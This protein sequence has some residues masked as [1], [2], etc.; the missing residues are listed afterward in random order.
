[1]HV[2]T[3]RARLSNVLAWFQPTKLWHWAGTPKRA[4]FWANRE[5]GTCIE[6]LRVFLRHNILLLC[7]PS[8]WK[9]PFLTWTLK[10]QIW[11]REDKG[12]ILRTT[13][14]LQSYSQLQVLLLWQEPVQTSEPS[15]PLMWRE[16]K[17]KRYRSTSVLRRQATCM[18]KG[19]TGC[20]VCSCFSEK[21]SI[22][23]WGEFTFKAST[24][25]S[26]RIGS[27]NSRV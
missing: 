19:L 7:L 15:L 11:R 13:R 22:E 26:M 3:Q 18:V 4:S 25:D 24:Q 21:K 6:P 8:L 23:D 16:H 12:L 2:K 5:R 1:M 14:S 9:K 10:Q 17:M 20:F 27:E